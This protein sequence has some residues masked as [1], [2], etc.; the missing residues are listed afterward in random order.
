MYKLN[1]KT[2]MFLI[3]LSLSSS[4]LSS[5]SIKVKDLKN[6][7]EST[8]KGQE[9]S[10]FERQQSPTILPN[11]IDETV[12]SLKTCNANNFEYFLR[13]T[14][15]GVFDKVSHVNLCK[16]RLC[17][18]SLGKLEAIRNSIANFES[19][20][21]LDLRCNGLE[22]DLFSEDSFSSLCLVLA[23]SKSLKRL[24]LGRVE[25][26]D[27]Q[28]TLKNHG[29]TYSSKIGAWVRERTRTLSPDEEVEQIVSGFENMEFR[30]D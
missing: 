28:L 6:F 4:E 15:Q 17:T 14:R 8:R 2:T 27:K 16:N 25:G 5:G 21:S 12:E 29:F 23:G 1:N 20:V 26:L 24:F 9:R 18:N 22:R 3:V 11:E 30:N 13:E 19:L 7:S 10:Q